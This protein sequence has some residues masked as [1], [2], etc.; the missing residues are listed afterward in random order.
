MKIRIDRIIA[1][2]TALAT[3]TIL[4]TAGGASAY[5]WDHTWWNSNM[6]LYVQEDNDVIR[7][8]DTLANGHA[9]RVTVDDGPGGEPTFTLTADRGTGTYED[10]TASGGRN[11]NENTTVTLT[12]DGDGGSWWKVTFYNDGFCGV[13]PDPGCG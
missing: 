11:L 3:A 6:K 5:S 10:S 8:A 7:V 9:A 13:S 12:A 4:A 1:G 2:A